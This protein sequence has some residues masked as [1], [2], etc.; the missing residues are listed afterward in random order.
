MSEDP[1]RNLRK[2]IPIIA[3]SAVVLQLLLFLLHAMIYETIVAAFGVTSTAL[4]IVFGFLSLTF[5]SATLLAA[6]GDNMFIRAY[7]RLAALWFSF[8]APLCAASVAFL[9]LEDVF[10]LWHWILPPATAGILSFAA[11]I[12]VGIYGIVNGLSIRTTRIAVPLANVP[13]GWRGKKIVFLSD[14]HLGA[15]R[16]A[17]FSRRIVAKVNA[18]APVLV[19]IG[20]DLF[21]G[22]KCDTEAYLA[23][24]KNLHA[25]EGVY[26]VT[27]NHEYIRTPDVFSAAIRAVGITILNNA[28]IDVNGL[29]L[30]GVDWRDTQRKEDLAG[31]LA[32]LRLDRDRPNIL[33]RHVPNNLEE[34]DRAGVKFQLSG[35][36]HRG[37]FW[38]LSIAT[39][40]FY[41]GFDYGLHRFGGMDIYTSSG[42]GT[43]MSPF[44]VGTKAEIVVVEFREPIS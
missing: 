35:H 13:E 10:P 2:F 20:G 21:D 41:H 37:Q 16:G 28:K 17:G 4:A 24:F 44:R 19:A 9:I 1:Q 8:V 23:P 26:F 18:L 43:W 42:I 7:Y 12:A 30:M 25:P 38:P 34:A 39:K 40:Y 5:L 22:T 14:V 36:T 6:A 33:L 15:M 32:R 3:A 29:D 31:V 11:A 27:G